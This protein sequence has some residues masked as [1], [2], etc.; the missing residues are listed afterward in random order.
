M[1]LCPEWLHL[2]E[3]YVFDETTGEVDFVIGLN[4]S[5]PWKVWE[6]WED[7]KQEHKLYVPHVEWF[8]FFVD[9]G[10]HKDSN[11]I[12]LFAAKKSE[13]IMPTVAD[14]EVLYLTE[15]NA[16]EKALNQA[17]INNRTNPVYL[18]SLDFCLK[19]PMAGIMD[20][21]ARKLLTEGQSKE[22]QIAH[23]IK[24]YQLSYG[25]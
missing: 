15:S 22:A 10:Y 7:V 6:P 20:H 16:S 9:D 3:L 12:E 1:V 13:R 23:L 14:H 21:W 5:T 19:Q 18:E 11:L 2:T 4:E 17:K 25:R 24:A 8:D